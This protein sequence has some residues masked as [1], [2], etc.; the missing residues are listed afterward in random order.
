MFGDD[1]VR[2]NTYLYEL[3]QSIFSALRFKLNMRKYRNERICVT[4]N[5]YMDWIGYMLDTCKWKWF[6]LIWIF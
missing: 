5:K 3:I 1:Y 6:D 2:H 4:E